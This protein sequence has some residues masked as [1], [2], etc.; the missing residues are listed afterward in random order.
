MT[1]GESQG[2]SGYCYK[3][4][5][6]GGEVCIPDYCER[7]EKFIREGL[8]WGMLGE[9][10]LANWEAHVRCVLLNRGSIRCG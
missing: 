8:K 2:K 5:L 10:S 1:G 3:G 6:G 9:G 4:E 7:A